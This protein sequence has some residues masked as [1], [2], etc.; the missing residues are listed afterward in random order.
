ML[1]GAAIVFAGTHIRIHDDGAFA[2]RQCHSRSDKKPGLARWMDI[3][4]SILFA[5]RNSAGCGD[6][7]RLGRGIRIIEWGVPP[8][9]RDGN[10]ACAEP[11]QHIDHILAAMV[12]E[13][14]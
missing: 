3:H 7:E 13:P 9:N 5:Y 8:K 10:D 2:C 12:R 14:A 11:L 1:L 6:V 4:R